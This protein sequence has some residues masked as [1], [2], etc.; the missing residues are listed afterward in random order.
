[1]D[2]GGSD[3]GVISKKLDSRKEEKGS[4]CLSSPDWQVL[5]I[6]YLHLKVGPAGVGCHQ[7]LTLSGWSGELEQVKEDRSVWALQRAVHDSCA[8][9]QHRVFA[10]QHILLSRQQLCQGREQR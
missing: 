5:P 3:N 7:Q 2:A 4:F 1:M 8:S 6:H 10:F 9:F